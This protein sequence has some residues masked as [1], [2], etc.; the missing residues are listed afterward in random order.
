MDDEVDEEPLCE[1][2]AE[3]LSALDVAML[4]CNSEELAA[5]M[6]VVRRMMASSRMASSRMASSTACWIVL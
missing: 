1:L 2:K 5:A 3:I 4:Q 6:A